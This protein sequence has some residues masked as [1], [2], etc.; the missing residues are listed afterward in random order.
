M[1][2]IGIFTYMQNNY[3][4]VL[5]A[6]ALQH[7]IRSHSDHDVETINF[8]T[9]EHEKGNKVI[10][11]PE[12]NIFYRVVFL[13]LQLFYYPSLKR[14]SD[15]IVDF[16]KQYMKFSDRHSEMAELLSNPP[17]KDIYISG[18]DQVFN[19]NG[20]YYPIYYLG[21][22]KGVGKKIAYAPSFGISQFDNK[23]REKISKYL[24]DFDALSCREQVGAE[25][26]SSIVKETVPT[27]VDPTMLLSKQEWQDIAVKPQI[28]SKY[29]FIYDLNGAEKLVAIAKKIQSKTQLPIVCLTRKVQ[30]F[31]R[32]DKQIYD[33]GPAEFIGW[34]ANAEYIVTDS[35]HGTVFSTIFKR[36]FY[37]YIATPSTASRI[38][39]LLSSLNLNDRLIPNNM[40]AQ[41]LNQNDI[42]PCTYTVDIDTISLESKEYIYNHIIL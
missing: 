30:K 3:G 37:S 15:R 34:I 35:F 6:Y 41:F 4:A 12:G 33:A 7:Y 22:E 1:K 17:Q 25:F 24:Y 23:I 38:Q 14:R 28:R 13:L 5:Q 20:K 39:T 32:I 2:K 31:Y 26:I 10:Q 36:N 42:S 8:T 27:V 16:K 19:P 9:P 11:I 40:V 21:F 18:S 29:I